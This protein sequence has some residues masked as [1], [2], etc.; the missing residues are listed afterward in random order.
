M[1]SAYTPIGL[2][3]FG[4]PL[5][6]GAWEGTAGVWASPETRP[7]APWDRSGSS[8]PGPQKGSGP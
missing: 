6:G 5:P 7:W 3:C 8:H 1:G 4:P 2:Q